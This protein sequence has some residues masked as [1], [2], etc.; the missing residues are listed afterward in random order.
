MDIQVLTPT[1]LRTAK[2]DGSGRVSVAVEAVSYPLS[3]V[4]ATIPSAGSL[5]PAIDLG[6][7]RLARIIVPDTWTPAA[8]TFQASINGTTWRDV[9]DS[10]G[11]EVSLTV[12]PGGDHVIPLSDFSSLDLIKLRSGTSAAPVAQTDA[13]ELI[14]VVM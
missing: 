6:D 13:A 11:A 2:G 5:T 7:L 4:T 10:Y 12:V 3:E 14:L 8:I 1:G 9:Y